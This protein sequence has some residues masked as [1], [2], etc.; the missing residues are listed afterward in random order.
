MPAKEMIELENYYFATTH[1]IA[2]LSK[3]HY[4]VNHLVKGMKCCNLGMKVKAQL[5]FQK[6]HPKNI[7]T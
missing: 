1:V 7:N 5:T 4:L 6:V 3:D 2:Y